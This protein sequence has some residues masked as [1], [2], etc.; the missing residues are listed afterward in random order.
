MTRFGSESSADT[1]NV[2]TNTVDRTWMFHV[3]HRS[4]MTLTA[5]AASAALLI[6]CA[7]GTALPHGWAPPV[8]APNGLLLV[9]SSAGKLALVKGDGSHI[10][11]YELK[12]PASRDF[13]GRSKQDAPSPLYATPIVEG[14]AVYVASYR[15]RIARLKLDGTSLNPSWD[16]EVHENVVATPVLRGNRLYIPSENGH[17]IVVDAGNGNVVSSTRP[18]SGRVWGAPGFRDSRLFIGTLDSSELLALNA[19]NGNVEWRHNGSGA[20]A[21]DLVIDGDQ[22]VVGSFDRTLH[23]LDAASGAERWRFEGN[24]WFVGRPLVVN[25]TIY[26]GTMRGAVYALDRSGKMKWVFERAGLEFR[27]TPV[28]AGSTLVVAD[29]DGDIVGLDPATGAEK[30]SKMA[31]VCTG[32]P[33]CIDAHGVQLESGVFFLTA[34]HRLLQVDPASG[35][36]RTTNISGDGK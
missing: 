18:T 33:E 13:I 31:D 34:D 14:D 16:V 22:L 24:G 23:A 28:L 5:L 1:V 26:V 20:T 6:G 7:S 29:R 21:A 36:I 32:K 19:D 27:S 12:G 8:A 30:W 25:D 9:Q 3:K 15:G 17:L 4:R 35:D 2:T 10:A 11:E